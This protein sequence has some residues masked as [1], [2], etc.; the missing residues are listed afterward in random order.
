M[1]QKNCKVD[2][3]FFF[4]WK[5]FPI[6]IGFE[7]EREGNQ[8]NHAQMLLLVEMNAWMAWTKGVILFEHNFVSEH[9]RNGKKEGRKVG[10]VDNLSTLQQMKWL[11]LYTGF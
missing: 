6:R 2:Q 10:V 7:R 3:S 4:V 5:Y 8:F 9:F 1:I 11:V